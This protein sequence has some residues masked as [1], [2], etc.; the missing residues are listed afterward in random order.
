[1]KN[2]GDFDEYLTRTMFEQKGGRDGGSVA[3][4]RPDGKRLVFAPGFLGGG[5]CH[6]HVTTRAH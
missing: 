2:G 5:S 4:L 3:L 1:M 6:R